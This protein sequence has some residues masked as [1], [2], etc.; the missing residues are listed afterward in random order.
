MEEIIRIRGISTVIGDRR[1]SLA[2][3]KQNPPRG[4]SPAKLRRRVAVKA[5]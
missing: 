4:G 1:D 5:W 2:A 3:F